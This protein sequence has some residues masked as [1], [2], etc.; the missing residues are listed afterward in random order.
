LW[1]TVN[2]S[3]RQ[4]TLDVTI[5]PEPTNVGLDPGGRGVEPTL[6]ELFFAHFAGLTRLAMC[7]VDDQP[8]A[9]DVVQD[10]YL[11]LYK[12]WGALRDPDKALTYLR[13]AVLNGARSQVRRRSRVRS[14]RTLHAVP[15]D[16]TSET[17]EQR[18]DRDAVYAA[19]R[20]LPQRQRE[21]MVLRYY[22]E[23]SEAQIA[24]T[25]GISTGSVKRHAYRA[26]EALTR[27]LEV[28][29]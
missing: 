24:D 11:S 13:S 19:V 28:Q 14:A 15:A 2:R 22:E 3:P 10:A 6:S 5:S 25:L 18:A 21:V 7:L 1:G 16:H 26:L 29:P 17:Y 27:R 20:D 4:A 12:R 9:E 23:L 8:T